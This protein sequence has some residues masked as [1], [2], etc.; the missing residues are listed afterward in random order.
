MNRYLLLLCYLLALLLLSACMITPLAPD[1]TP[2]P[3]TPTPETPL[4][5]TFTPTTAVT[6]T[7]PTLLNNTASIANGLQYHLVA[8]TARASDLVRLGQALST[9]GQ[10]LQV[11]VAANGVIQVNNARVVQTD[12]V[13]SNG[14]IH[15]IDAVLSPPT[16]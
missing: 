5:P 16:Q 6:E 8:D 9:S 11:T 10:P 4:Q 1:E 12:I 14:V 13:T 7:T 3:E 2:T 15:L